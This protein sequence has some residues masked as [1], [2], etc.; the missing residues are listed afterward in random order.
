MKTEVQLAKRM[1]IADFATRH[2]LTMSLR[3][4]PRHMCP[5]ESGRWI[6]SFKNVETKDCSSSGV[7]SGTYGNGATQAKAIADYARQLSGRLLIIGAY[8]PDRREIWADCDFTDDA[9]HELA[10]CLTPS[11]EQIQ[12]PQNRDD[13]ASA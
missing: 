4:R 7:L 12:F 5:E 11:D 8:T 13:E 10:V 1:T 2:G 6:A 9:A 3:E